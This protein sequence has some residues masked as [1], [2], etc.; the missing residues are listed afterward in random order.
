MLLL[1]L[2]LNL[3]NLNEIINMK[4]VIVLNM[5]KRN[6]H[7]STTGKLN[8]FDCPQKETTENN[9][10]ERRHT[11][12]LITAE[13]SAEYLLKI[14]FNQLETEVFK[15]DPG[16]EMISVAV[17]FDFVSSPSHLQSVQGFTIHTASLFSV[18]ENNIILKYAVTIQRY[19]L[20]CN[21]KCGQEM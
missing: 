3:L 14:Q 13:L 12:F 6:H 2:I 7:F 17:M 8:A 1:L 19:W 5:L 20:F 16:L 10:S 11:L 15:S 18:S 9:I 4:N 21:V